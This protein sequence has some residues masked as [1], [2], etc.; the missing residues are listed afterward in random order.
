MSAAEWWCKNLTTHGSS[1][2]AKH[3]NVDVIINPKSR[4][5]ERPQ[6]KQRQNKQRPKYMHTRNSQQQPQQK[7]QRQDNSIH[8]VKTNLRIHRHVHKQ[9]TFPNRHQQGC[10]R[11]SRM[12]HGSIQITRPNQPSCYQCGETGHLRDSCRNTSKLR[13]HDECNELEHKA[14]HCDH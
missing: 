4:S 11:S 7:Y 12:I 2:Q 10:G 3:L 13:C 14:I 9:R 8:K 5:Q 6:A 1:L